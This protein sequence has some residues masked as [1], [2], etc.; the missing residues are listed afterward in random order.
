VIPADRSNCATSIANLPLAMQI[1]FQ[2]S[3]TTHMTTSKQ[4]DYLNRPSSISSTPSNSFVCQYDAANQCAMDH[5]WDNSYF[6]QQLAVNN[7]ASAFW[8]NITVT[9][10]GSRGSGHAYVA[11]T[12][13]TYTYEADGN[14]LSDGRWTNTW[15]AENRLLSMTSL[16]SAPSSSLLQLNF[17]Y[18]SQ[19]RRIQK[20][21]CTNS[22]SGYVGEFTNKYAY[23]GWNCL[24]V[25]NHSLGLSN[26]FLWGSDLSGSLRGAGGVG[27]LIAVSYNYG[28]VTTNCFIAYDGNGKVSALIK[29]GDGTTQANYEYGP[30]GELLRATGPMAKLNPFRFST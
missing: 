28:T 9:N 2:D 1:T 3:G 26:S 13:E 20:G 14:L 18:D 22:G 12:P 17:I 4:H 15:D 29:E 21:V 23:D 5:L 11:Q 7:S 16:A 6:R 8:T 19:G 27:G 25:F 30:S 10:S 24:A